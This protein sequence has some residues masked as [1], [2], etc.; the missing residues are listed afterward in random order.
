[1]VIPKT[2][3]ESDNIIVSNPR[4][5][6]IAR[7]AKGA[8]VS[9]SG[10]M[11]G[12]GL[13]FLV[14]LILARILGPEAFGLYAIGWTIIR[15]VS[16]IGPLGLDSGVI[17]FGAKYWREDQ[18]NFR[19]VFFLS[20]GI[21]LASGLLIG[22]AL[23]LS[24]SFLSTQVFHKPG[25]ES[26]VRGFAFAIPLVTTLRVM[27][28][29]TSISQRMQYATYSEEISQPSMELMLVLVFLYL[30]HW[31]LE[32]AVLAGVISFGV[33]LALATYY[34][35]RIYPGKLFYPDS[36]MPTR[37][38]HLQLDIILFSIP[39]AFAAFFGTYISWADRLL[40]GFFRSEAETGVYTTISLVSSI[41][42]IILSGI[43][44]IFSPMIADLYHRGEIKRVE[45]IFR[46][47]TKWALYVSTPLLLVILF[48]SR[49]LLTLA[50]GAQYS[51]G[52]LA[53]IFLALAQIIHIG[54]GAIDTL[55]IMTGRQKSWLVISGIMLGLNILVNSILIPAYGLIG[56]ALG[57]AA[58]VSGIVII[59]L[60]I[61]RRDL[62]IWPYDRRYFKGLVS[63]LACTAILIG[64]SA[65]NFSAPALRLFVV[66][67]VA[68]VTFGAGLLV[69]GLDSEDREL[70]SMLQ[71][72]FI[73]RPI[74]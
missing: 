32:G 67:V 53:L 24:A 10:K 62:K 7:L 44:V 31:N 66:T 20:I 68:F 71:R 14:Q 48:A 1:M 2:A 57:T 21:S 34:L 63:A 8:G 40:V 59:G 70:L 73:I 23:F 54:T 33:A 52:S 15:I 69:Q 3:E 56:A 60:M 30:F 36:G 39:T 11:V 28:A 18:V 13:N 46:F 42:V 72:K 51:S 12:R 41:F 25:L 4:S 17:R 47:S 65:V 37:Q 58:T 45:E 27:A 64:V 61:V 35:V 5:G 6:D 9:A 16:I 22:S 26:V 49:E 43:K 55:L 19:R 74:G 38:A 29:A 50:F